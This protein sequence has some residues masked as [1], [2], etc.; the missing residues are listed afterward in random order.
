MAK[1]SIGIGLIGLGV[2]GGQVA[3]ELIDRQD[4]LSRHC[5]GSVELKR[6]KVLPSDLEKPLARDLPR[7]LFS[8]SDDIFDA[9]GIDVIIELIGGENPAYDFIK[10][11]LIHGKHV[12][13]ANK[14][15]IAKHGP[16]LINLAQSNGV[17]IYFEASVGGGIPLI[18]PLRDDLKANNITGIHAIINGTTNYI[19]TRMSQEGIGFESALKQAQE[20]GYAEANPVNDIEGI[21][22]A[23]KLAIMATLAFQ[24]EVKPEDVYHEGISKLDS[25]DFK[26]AS[27]LGYA[28]KLLAIALQYNHTI[29]ARVHPVFIKKEAFLAKVNGVFNAVSIEGDLVGQVIFS[30]EG[31]GPMA[32][33]SAV[34]S[35]VLKAC[36]DVLTGASNPVLCLDSRKIIKPV[37]SI[38][39]RY[40]LRLS[41]VDSPGVLAEISRIL[42]VHDISISSVIQKETDDTSNTAEIVIMTHLASGESM[43]S[44]LGQLNELKVIKEIN[45]II[46]VEEL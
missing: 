43:E 14:E 2:I 42:G 11:S 30:G 29:E 31:A 32:T 27:E 37:T 1:K 6:I 35:D 33:S 18:S 3:R 38:T 4:L 12:V 39:T 25:R 45:N 8:T 9:P 22:A 34:L 10:R 7:D 46:R 40:Y 16:E 44:A 26:Y 17:S 19:L 24:G 5:G 20:L 21:D 23:Y 41:V 36:R 15:V 13:T 28:I